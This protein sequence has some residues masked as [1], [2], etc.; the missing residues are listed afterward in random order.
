[1]NSRSIMPKGRGFE[2]LGAAMLSCG[3]WFP[4]LKN[5]SVMAMCLSNALR[6][7]YAPLEVEMG[8]RWKQV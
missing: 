1:M 8:A 4:H 2:P 7:L 3:D 5:K 6:A